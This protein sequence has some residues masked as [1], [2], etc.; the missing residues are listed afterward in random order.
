MDGFENEYDAGPPAPQEGNVYCA[1]HGE[2]VAVDGEGRPSHTG[3]CQTCYFESRD[4]QN[5]CCPAHGIQPRAEKTGQCLVCEQLG[6]DAST[7]VFAGK[8]IPVTANQEYDPG[9]QAH[10]VEQ[11]RGSV[12][13]STQPKHTA[14]GG[15][16]AGGGARSADGGVPR[17]PG[18]GSGSAPTGK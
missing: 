3:M 12:A 1:T 17:G 11:Y 18:S 9:V 8:D 7:L 6:F 10:G 14:V 15:G 5:V 13:G 16:K 2:R 4:Q